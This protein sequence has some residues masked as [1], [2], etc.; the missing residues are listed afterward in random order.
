[1]VEI[2]QL[3]ITDLHA[4]IARRE[5]AMREEIPVIKVPQDVLDM[6]GRERMILRW[7]LGWNRTRFANQSL[8]IRHDESRLSELHF[9]SWGYDPGEYIKMDEDELYHPMPQRDRG[10]GTCELFGLRH[11][12]RCSRRYL[13]EPPQVKKFEKEWRDRSTTDERKLEILWDWVR[14]RWPEDDIIHR[15]CRGVAERGRCDVFSRRGRG[16]RYY[17]TKT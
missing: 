3:S 11:C 5:R 1:M 8:V 9:N 10:N 6:V 17:E 7:N 14:L 2:D 15:N 16:R 4:E 13:L 12:Y